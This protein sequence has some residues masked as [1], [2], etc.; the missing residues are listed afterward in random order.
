[1]ADNTEVRTQKSWT[2]HPWEGTNGSEEVSARIAFFFHFFQRGWGPAKK[3]KQKVGC[4][5][6]W[7]D[8]HSNRR[9][10]GRFRRSKSWVRAAPSF[11][12]GPAFAMQVF[13]GLKLRPITRGRKSRQSIP[14]PFATF[15]VA[16]DWSAPCFLQPPQI[17][18]TNSNPETLNRT[19]LDVHLN[20]GFGKR[21][22]P[23]YYPAKSCKACPEPKKPRGR[24]VRGR[25]VLQFQVV[26]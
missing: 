11:H 22:M 25:P 1:M 13:P 14:P 20:P 21:P 18:K 5:F 9:P 6:W 8:V 23:R 15:Y 2:G 16:E 3:M 12:H 7:G 24:T 4:L 19:M 17:R 10:M 26:D